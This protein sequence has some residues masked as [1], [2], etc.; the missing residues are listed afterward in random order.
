MLKRLSAA[1]IYIYVYPRLPRLKPIFRANKYRPLRYLTRASATTVGQKLKYSLAA[2]TT[3]TTPYEFRGD[4]HA[5]RRDARTM[6]DVRYSRSRHDAGTFLC[7]ADGREQSRLTDILA[8]IITQSAL[9][10]P[11]IF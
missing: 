6:K 9:T 1:D 7:N 3:T 5:G 10:M 8:A 11:Y 4:I 2:S